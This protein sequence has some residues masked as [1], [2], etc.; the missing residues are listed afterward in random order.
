MLPSLPPMG[1]TADSLIHRAVNFASRL[2]QR[3]ELSSL[4]PLVASCRSAISQ[5]EVSVAVVGRFKAGKSSFINHFTNRS[6]LPVGVVPV[7]A[8]VTE[9][10]FGPIERAAVHFLDGRVQEVSVDGIATYVSERDN[11]E[12]VKRV[13]LIT[14]ELPGLERFRGLK[15]VDTPGLESVLV[16]NTEAALKWLPNV[17]LALLTV[18]V[19]P[20][21]S[22]QDIE[23]LKKLY[24]FTPNVTVLI[25]KVD[26]LAPEERSEVLGFVTE[27]LGKAFERAPHV[28]PYSIR[29]GHE[30]LKASL[31]RNVFQ[32]VL[33]RFGEERRA[34]I[35][36]KIDTLLR[37]C[38]DYITL[39]LKSAELLGTQREALKEQLIGQQQV[40]SDVKSQL[41]LIAHHAAAGTRTF[42]EGRF[43]SHQK[44]IEDRLLNE[45]ATEFP[46]WTKSLGFLLDSYDRWLNSAMAEH[47]AK[48]SVAERSRLSEPLQRVASQIRRILQDFRDRL[49]DGTMR[50]FRIPLRTTEVEMEIHEPESPDIRIGK[51]FDRNWELL[52]PIVPVALIK[53]VVR[54]HFEREVSYKLF[55]NLSRLASQWEERINSALLNI[56]K[57][58]ERRLDELVAT[59]RHLIE[60]GE[61]DRLPAIRQ[62][63][64]QIESL[65][66]AISDTVGH[67]RT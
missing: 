52:S 35:A 3:Y 56:Q 38:S 37:E 16:H 28:A 22:H 11:P 59:V 54:S 55:T 27:Q 64:E 40:I 10:R 67:T 65:R 6:I 7:T 21:L 51:I 33:S 34:I 42:A 61:G 63:L 60:N 46:K 18:S 12:N 58:A 14:V 62:D 29:P 30:D 39:S 43:E 32:R 24:Q 9:I 20:P 66:R 47:L 45:L 25:T 2:A 23:L 53:G 36:R 19:D 49:S 17:G 31:E 1:A 50:A 5:N 57:E 8:V 48:I 44:G 13:K 26:L 15:F 4:A 41:R